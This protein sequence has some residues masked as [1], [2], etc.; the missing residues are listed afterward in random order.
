MIL[1]G[2]AGI[3]TA[4]REPDGGRYAFPLLFVLSPYILCTGVTLA[5]EYE[6][7]RHSLV[8]LIMMKASAWPLITMLTEEKIKS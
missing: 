4:F 5:D 3:I 1:I 6:F 2:A 7:A 8:I